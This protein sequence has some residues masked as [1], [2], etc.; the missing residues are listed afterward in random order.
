MIRK[1]CSTL[2]CCCLL[3]LAKSESSLFKSV[4]TLQARARTTTDFENL[5]EGKSWIRA[6]FHC[7]KC[8][9]K[10]AHSKREFICLSNVPNRSL[11]FVKISV[12]TPMYLSV[13]AKL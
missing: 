2:Q 3:S 12:L 10:Q 5:D 4:N 11:N 1:T 9:I 13:F 7:F 8:L 6:V